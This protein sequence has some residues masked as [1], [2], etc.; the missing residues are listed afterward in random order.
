MWQR[1]GKQAGLSPMQRGWMYFLKKPEKKLMWLYP[2]SPKRTLNMFLEYP[3]E[4][5]EI[6]GLGKLFYPIIQLQRIPYFN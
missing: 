1:T 4:Y 5:A 2:G 3:F 6:K